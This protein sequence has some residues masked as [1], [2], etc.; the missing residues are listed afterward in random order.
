MHIK[1][2]LGNVID[3]VRMVIS[4]VLL[5]FSNFYLTLLSYIIYHDCFKGSLHSSGTRVFKG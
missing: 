4:N 2:R 5:V 1:S 3:L